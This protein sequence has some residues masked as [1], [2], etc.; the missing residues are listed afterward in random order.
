MIITQFK[1]N[2]ILRGLFAVSLIILLADPC[3]HLIA[4][5]ST[6]MSDEKDYRSMSRQELRSEMPGVQEQ[7][8]NLEMEFSQRYND[9]YRTRNN[10]FV[11][12]KADLYGKWRHKEA[13]AEAKK[14]GINEIEYRAITD[15]L[16][17]TVEELDF[18]PKPVEFQEQDIHRIDP[19]FTGAKV[20]KKE[21]DDL[22]SAVVFNPIA[23]L[24]GIHAQNMNEINKG[25]IINKFEILQYGEPKWAREKY[26][27]WREAPSKR[28]N[29]KFEEDSE[30]LEYRLL[31]S[32]KITRWINYQAVYSTRHGL[33]AGFIHRD[34]FFIWCRIS[35]EEG[36]FNE[37]S[38][39]WVKMRDNCKTLIDERLRQLK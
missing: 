31:S 12:T 22:Y 20:M 23:E 13:M 34:T 15:R 37:I 28:Q 16:E 33:E 19:L 38:E 7:I 32:S 29:A 21:K 14:W 24:Q 9:V 5:S 3:G 36:D 18:L 27:N 10:K 25:L 2:N 26:E 1:N 35:T 17:L 8:K 6:G 11:E 39:R 30:N 4:D